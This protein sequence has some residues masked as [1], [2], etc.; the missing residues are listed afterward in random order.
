MERVSCQNDGLTLYSGHVSQATTL[1]RKALW[2]FRKQG[3]MA[4]LDEVWGF[5][6]RRVSGATH[7]PVASRRGN[8][9]QAKN[10]SLHLEPGEWV[11][12]K[13]E[14]EILASVDSQWRTQGLQFV[15]EMRD[16]FGHR[17]RVMRRVRKICV[18]DADGNVREVRSLKSTVLLEG[19]M[20]RGGG[21]GCDRCC[22]Y[23]WRESWLKRLG[24]D[25]PQA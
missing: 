10:A 3:P 17:L 20:C 4:M 25:K 5:V 21:I 12:V 13:S 14:E 22:H 24:A 11:E 1:A 2:I 8:P 7:P 19:A 9:E 16:Y 6:A 15:P 18:E 23:F